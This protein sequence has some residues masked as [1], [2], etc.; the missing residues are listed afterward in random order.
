MS[1]KKLLLLPHII[2]EVN[3]SYGHPMENDSVHYGE[4]RQRPKLLTRGPLGA[5]RLEDG[6]GGEKV[7]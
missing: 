1:L 3:L 5:L 2:N 7:A 6:N 4:L